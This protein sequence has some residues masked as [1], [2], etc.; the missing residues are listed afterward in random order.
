MG[1][2]C[3]VGLSLSGFDH[4]IANS[5]KAAPKQCGSELPLAAPLPLC[6][7][8][9]SSSLPLSVSHLLFF[10]VSSSP[11]FS[12]PSLFISLSITHTPFFLLLFSQAAQHK[13]YTHTHTHTHTHSY[14]HGSS[15][16][17]QAVSPFIW[18]NWQ[19]F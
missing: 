6:S 5:V 2:G 7:P 9:L 14:T 16:D 10:A 18:I 8:S 1:L 4:T 19:W 11:F 15:F 17:H 3:G 13:L 12:S